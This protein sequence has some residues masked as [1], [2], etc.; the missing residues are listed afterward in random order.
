MLVVV[1]TL[2]LSPPLLLLSDD[3]YQS[4]ISTAAAA[5]VI[6]TCPLHISGQVTGAVHRLPLLAFPIR[7]ELA[8]FNWSLIM[9][10][11]FVPFCTFTAAVVA[12]FLHTVLSFRPART[13]SQAQSVSVCLLTG[14]A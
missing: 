8:N 14:I 4:L 3:L 13:A 12:G 9:R 2:A 5:A 11:P 6:F 7:N 1:V 10:R